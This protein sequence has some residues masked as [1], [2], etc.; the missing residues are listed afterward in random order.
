[1]SPLETAAPIELS[2]VIPAYDEVTRISVTVARTLE[3]LARTYPRSEVIVVDDGSNDDTPLVLAELSRL[4]PRL[5]VIRHE[6]NHGKGGAVKSG[7]LAARGEFVLFM[8]ADLATPIEEL[9][10]VLAY[11]RAGADVVVGSRAHG[12]GTEIRKRQPLPREL[13]GRTFNVIVR[14]LLPI[15]IADTQCGFKLFRRAAA[16]AIFART[17]LEGF[18]FD[19]ELLMLAKQLGYEVRDVPVV[20]SHG[21]NSK[22]RMFRDS[23]KMLLDI[24][25]IRQ[26]F[27]KTTR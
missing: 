23:S 14:S 7:V 22:V 26:R 17:T 18:A 5:V 13:M 21:P 25:S 6:T 19:V 9:P 24:W 20:W 1:M 4:D 3:F 12:T 8:D 16:Q 11:A 2:V 15:D 10:K 27:A